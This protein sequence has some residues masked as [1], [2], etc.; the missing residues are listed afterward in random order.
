VF[1]LRVGVSGALEL[2]PRFRPIELCVDADSTESNV[3]RAMDLWNRLKL[4]R[5]QRVG[6]GSRVLGRLWIHGGGPVILGREIVLEGEPY[7]IELHAGGSG[8]IKIGDRVIIRAGCSIEA[9]DLIE[10]GRDCVL[11]PY[12]KIMDSQFHP[13]RGD[14]HFR[15]PPVRVCIEEGAIIGARTIL[16]P[17]AHVQAGARIGPSSVISRR[18]P[19]GACVVGNPPRPMPDVKLP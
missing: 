10:I 8:V 7:P 4:W 6:A 15:P 12:V 13:L 3:A 19:A 11:G 2:R 9:I 1:S 5:C 18:V 17:G 14:R 16:L